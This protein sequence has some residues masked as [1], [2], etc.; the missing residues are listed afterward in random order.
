[1][2]KCVLGVCSEDYPIDPLHWDPYDQIMG[3]IIVS[4]YIF[5]AELIWSSVRFDS[6]SDHN[7]NKIGLVLFLLDDD[8]ATCAYNII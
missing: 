8:M 4:A 3:V 7:P 1:M 6:G 2:F 5:Y